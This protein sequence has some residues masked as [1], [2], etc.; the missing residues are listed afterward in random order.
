MTKMHSY[1]IQITL[2]AH[3]L[4]QYT[5]MCLK[6]LKGKFGLATLSSVQFYKEIF[7]VLPILEFLET[8]PDH[9]KVP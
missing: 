3:S 2:V 5:I 8:R 9:N 4:Y 1:H 7:Q 6:H